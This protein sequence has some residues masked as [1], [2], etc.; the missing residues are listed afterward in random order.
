M[1]RWWTSHGQVIKK[2]GTTQEQALNKSSHEEAMDKSR[3][4]HG[5]VI[6]MSWT[7]HV[8]VMNKPWTSNEKLRQLALSLLL[9]WVGGWWVQLFVISNPFQPSKLGFSWSL[10]WLWQK[11]QSFPVKHPVGQYFIHEPTFN[12]K[13][14]TSDP[15]LRN[16]QPLLILKHVQWNESSKAISGGNHHGLEMNI[17]WNSGHGGQFFSFRGLPTTWF[18]FLPSKVGN[19]NPLKRP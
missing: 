18:F 11:I 9:F 16:R 17:F 2:L 1:S 14:S 7:N 19:E 8:Q 10:G 12:C 15:F 5:Q 4:G 13:I 6:N 3:T